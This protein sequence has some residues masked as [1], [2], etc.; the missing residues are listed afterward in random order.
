MFGLT[1]FLFVSLLMLFLGSVVLVHQLNSRINR[2]FFAWTVFCVFWMVTNYLENV[3]WFSLGARNFFLR[4]DFASAMLA[5]G[6]VMLFAIN[7]VRPSVKVSTLIKYFAPAVVL[8]I[9]SYTSLIISHIGITKSGEI[10]FAQEFGFYVYALFVIAYFAIPC[11]VLW[12]ARRFAQPA[13]RPQLTSIAIGTSLTAVVSLT[14][15]L[16]L[17]NYISA[18]WFRVGIYA[19]IFFVVGVFWAIV[20]HE[21]LRIRLV[22]VELLLLGILATIMARV[23]TSASVVDIVMNIAV[24]LVMLVLGFAMVRSFLN[25]ERQRE[26]LQVLNASLE[27][28]NQDLLKLD[29]LKNTMLS[30]ASHQLRGPLGGI[31]GYLT[32]M[33]E[34]DLGAIN[35]NQREVL[36]MNLNVLSRLL[37]AVETFLDIGMLESGKISLHLETVAL[38]ETISNIIEEFVAPMR[39]K[40][41]AMS[42][43]CLA[44]RPVL[45][46]VDADK[47][48]HIVFNVVDNALKYTERGS[49]RVTLE[50]VE[51]MA[52]VKIVDTGPGMSAADLAHL[53]HKFERGHFVTDKGGSGLGLYVVKMLAEM[54]GGRVKAE[55]AGVGQ[56]TVFTLTFPLAKSS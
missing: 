38:D 34:G 35:D 22:V 21:F 41:L 25:E 2:L 1:V 53:F 49:V 7:Y 28:S 39:R 40:G 11:V 15:N 4:T 30:V 6:F 24:F 43:E 45:A 18:E 12:R 19:V 3:P 48:Q 29:N 26:K 42:Y 33:K 23:V 54:Q 52:V 16:F 32:M 9:S 55:S 46:R 20:R 5:V 27:K 47:V 31:R 36:A 8:A 44:Q 17:Q 10:G 14:V 56:G 13:Q 50:T 37:S 51:G